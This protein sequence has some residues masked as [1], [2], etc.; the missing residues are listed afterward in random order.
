MLG[1]NTHFSNIK[2]RAIG[3]LGAALPLA[4]FS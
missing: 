1:L 4:V 3:V 2:R